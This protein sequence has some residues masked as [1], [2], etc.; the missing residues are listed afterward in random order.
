MS[1]H[2]QQLIEALGLKRLSTAKARAALAG[3]ELSVIEGDT[4]RL[5]LVATRWSLTKRFSDLAEVE[6]WLDRV[7]GVAA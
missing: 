5:E 3:V 2:L 6:A 4:G 1:A 7:A